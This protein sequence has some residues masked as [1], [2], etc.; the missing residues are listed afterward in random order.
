[1]FAKGNSALAKKFIAVAKRNVAL[2]EK[3]IAVANCNVALAEKFIAVAN[4]NVAL[5]AKLVAF[6]NC[7][8]ALAAKLVAFVNCNVAL[9]EKFV[10]FCQD[11]LQIR[12]RPKTSHAPAIVAAWSLPLS[13][14]RGK[15]GRCGR[16]SKQQEPP[17]VAHPFLDAI[18]CTQCVILPAK[19]RSVYGSGGLPASCAGGADFSF[20][21]TDAFL[22]RGGGRAAPMLEWLRTIKIDS[23]G[24]SNRGATL[25]EA[26]A[27]FQKSWD[28]WK[29]W[30]KLEEVA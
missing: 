29:A 10:A 20:V 22:F 6:A 5:A 8:V 9:A 15:R 18:D 12:K 24:S 28:A 30:T 17:Y 26:K 4:C 7:N 13:T 14:A 19:R 23:A 21:E 11:F 25:E 1:V 16:E 2:A 27:Q 3:F